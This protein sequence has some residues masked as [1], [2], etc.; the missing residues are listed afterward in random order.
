MLSQWLKYTRKADNKNL[1]VVKPKNRRIIVPF[2]FAVCCSKNRDMLRSKQLVEYQIA[3]DYKHL[4]V[5]F[6]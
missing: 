2:K 6:L 5:K 4:E 3:S 1:K